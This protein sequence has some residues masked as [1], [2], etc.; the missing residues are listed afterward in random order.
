MLSTLCAPAKDASTS[1]GRHT[2]R[3]RRS[4]TIPT[5]WPFAVWGLDMVGPL[6][7]APR[8]YTHLLVAID[9][10]TKWIEAKLVATITVEWT[11]EFFRGIVHPFGI[12][13]SII[14]DNGT[15][16]N[17]DAFLRFCNDYSID[18]SFTA[19]AHPRT[20]EEAEPANGLI[21]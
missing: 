3:L 4:K 20:N 15:Q 18:L 10:F 6:K 14:T 2:C 11:A 1:P 13:N 21:K 16:F 7:S 9:E 12:P 8:G 17:G 5:T 19:V